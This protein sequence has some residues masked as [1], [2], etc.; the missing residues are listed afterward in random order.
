MFGVISKTTVN[1]LTQMGPLLQKRTGCARAL[2]ARAVFFGKVFLTTITKSS[3]FLQHLNQSR[4]MYM[5]NKK[6]Y[7]DLGFLYLAAVSVFVN[8]TK[9]STYIETASGF[10]WESFS[11]QTNTFLNINIGWQNSWIRLFTLGSGLDSS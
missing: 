8:S 5:M 7:L 10:L 4:N 3:H 6:S 9:I 11:H 2:I 1:G